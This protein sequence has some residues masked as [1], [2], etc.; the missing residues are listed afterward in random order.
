MTTDEMLDRLRAPFPA[1]TVQWR[2]GSTT[3]DKKRGLA[4]PYMNKKMIIDRLDQVMGPANWKDASTMNPDGKTVTVELSLRIDG[5]WIAKSDGAGQTDHEGEKGAYSDAFKR[6][7]MK[8]GIGLYLFDVPKEWIEIEPFHDS[9]R[10]PNDEFDYLASKLTLFTKKLAQTKPVLAPSN[11]NG[12]AKAPAAPAE[13]QRQY[14]KET[15]SNQ[16][17]PVSEPVVQQAAPT[18]TRKDLYQECCDYAD[19]GD[20]SVKA[21]IK[22]LG[23]FPSLNALPETAVRQMAQN[24]L[25]PFVLERY[26]PETKLELAATAAQGA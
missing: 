23:T 26:F 1:N 21:Y 6:A 24:F 17:P 12:S 14:V 7:A 4:I 9:Y 5:E 19:A 11:G 8:W 10:I 13:T 22:Q 20:T 3:K 2:L 15:D 16:A 18:W 25:P